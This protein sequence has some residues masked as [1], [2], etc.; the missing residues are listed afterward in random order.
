MCQKNDA[1]FYRGFQKMYRVVVSIYGVFV[2]L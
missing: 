2:F 1:L